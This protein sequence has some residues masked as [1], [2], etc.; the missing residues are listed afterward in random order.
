MEDLLSLSLSL[1]SA[2]ITDMT[3]SR[4]VP[5]VHRGR[6]SVD[7]HRQ[8]AMFALTGMEVFAS[9][10]ALQETLVGFTHVHTVAG[11]G[12]CCFGIIFQGSA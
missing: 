12:F 4:P 9:S 7:T 8:L 2:A 3:S 6:R 10:S 5:E 11:S 1:P